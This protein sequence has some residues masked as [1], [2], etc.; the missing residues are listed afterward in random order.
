MYMC[1]VI[2]GGWEAIFRVTMTFIRMILFTSNNKIS[3]TVGN[4]G[5]VME[6]SDG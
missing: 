3:H 1:D 2:K 6:G 4:E 5:G